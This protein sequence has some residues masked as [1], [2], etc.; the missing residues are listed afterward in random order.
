MR[1]MA[2]LLSMDPHPQ[3]IPSRGREAKEPSAPGL[4]KYIDLATTPPSPLRGW[5]EG[6]GPSV[7]TGEGEN[8]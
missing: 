7:I 3:S 8:A 1:E 4:E 5:I 6:G 2:L